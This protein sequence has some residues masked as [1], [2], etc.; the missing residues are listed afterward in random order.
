MEFALQVPLP[1][2][3]TQR[4]VELLALVIGPIPGS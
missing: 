3:T 1:Q 2:G 4:L